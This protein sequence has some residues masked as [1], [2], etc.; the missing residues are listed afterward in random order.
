MIFYRFTKFNF[1]FKIFKYNSFPLICE[2]Q[3]VTFNIYVAG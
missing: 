3:Y 1:Y 2:Y